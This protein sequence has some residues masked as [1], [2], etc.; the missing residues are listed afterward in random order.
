MELTDR[1]TETVTAGVLGVWCPDEVE[2]QNPGKPASD[3]ITKGGDGQPAVA[4]PRPACAQ[5]IYSA[6]F[7]LRPTG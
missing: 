7:A 1:S 2:G 3:E 6:P 4:A 5:A